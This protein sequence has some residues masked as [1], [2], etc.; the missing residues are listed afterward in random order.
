M[1]QNPLH[2]CFLYN[3]VACDG[4]TPDEKPLGGTESAMIFMAQALAA[5]GHDV[6][7]FTNTDRPGIYSGVCYHPY[8]EFESSALKKSPDIL[9]GIRQ[10]LPLLSRRWATVQ[11]YLSPDAYDQPA[12]NSSM[13]ITIDIPSQRFD[14]G[15]FSLKY[16]HRFIDGII[17]VGQWQAQ[18]FIDR[19]KVSPEKVFVGLNGVALE[20][21]PKPALLSQRKKQIVYT[22]TPFRGLKELLEFFPEIKQQVSDATCSI[23]SG[24]QTYG[25]SDEDNIKEYGELYQK[26]QQPGVTLYG[27]KAKREMIDILEESR[28]LAYPNTFAETFCISALEAQAAGLPVVTTELA[29]LTERVRHSEDGF[30]ISGLPSQPHY[31]NDFIYYVVRCLTD[32]ALWSRL[33]YSA[34]QKSR[35]Y[36]YSLLAEK[37]E[38]YFYEKLMTTRSTSYFFL[39]KD[40]KLSV[41]VAG[42]PKQIEL[43][44]ESITEWISK[45]AKMSDT[46]HNFLVDNKVIEGKK[47]SSLPKKTSVKRKQK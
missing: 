3:G 30:L 12:L 46:V 7:V 16:V 17:C 18:T 27:P 10:L 43:K 24:M 2:I 25:V 31:K 15:L 1:P 39:P 23:L 38:D 22:S 11:L 42:Y 28:V 5:R 13:N 29:G 21:F 44:K 4:N 47:I 6:H 37:W 35:A 32:D 9:V 8:S 41:M 14:V 19:F 20:Y 36:A 33:S 40:E 34:Y 45:G 26:A